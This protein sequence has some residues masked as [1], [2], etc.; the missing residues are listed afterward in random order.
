[1]YERATLI[2]IAF[3]QRCVFNVEVHVFYLIFYLVLLKSLFLPSNH[4]HGKTLIII[5]PNCD[6]KYRGL[7]ARKNMNIETR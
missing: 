4:N 3:F 5:V 7:S 2:D 1:M 6:E